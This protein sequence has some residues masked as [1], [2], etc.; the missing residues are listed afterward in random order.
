MQVPLLKNLA[1]YPAE[2]LAQPDTRYPAKHTV[3]V[4]VIWPDNGF[5]K[6]AGYPTHP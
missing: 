5:Q 3:P 2:Y 6:M 1:R 4:S